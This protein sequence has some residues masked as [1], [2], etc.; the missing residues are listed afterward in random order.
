MVS[1]LTTAEV[2]PRVREAFFADA[3]D[4]HANQAETALMLA[5]APALARPELCATADDPDRTTGLVF[6]HPVNRTSLNGVTGTPSRAT[7]AEG[8][9]LFGW[10]VTDLSKTI[11]CA[12]RENAP[13]TTPYFTNGPNPAAC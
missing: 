10:I 4:W 8:E 5:R 6:A 3:A 12:L 2:S 11:R 9:R 7:V 13:L 1:E